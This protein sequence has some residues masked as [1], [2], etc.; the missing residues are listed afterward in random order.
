[1]LRREKRYLFLL[2]SV[3][4][5]TV[6]CGVLYS[7]RSEA[8]NNTIPLS[9][10]TGTWAVRDGSG[11]GTIDGNPFN[12]IIRKGSIKI[13]DIR[14]DPDGLGGY[15]DE[16]SKLIWEI[17]DSNWEKILES[18][19][20]SSP[21]SIHYE[22]TGDNQYSATYR[23]ETVAVTL[24]SENSGK[25]TD[26]VPAGTYIDGY[27]VSANLT[28]Y[29]D[30]VSDSD[31]GGCGNTGVGFAGILALLAISALRKN[32]RLGDDLTYEQESLH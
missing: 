32:A 6:F 4:L 12:V 14:L 22:N 16:S 29:V 5:V 30:K 15:V 2:A 7:E 13:T 11:S 19:F 27:Q 25:V 18:P 3:L 21:H 31:G 1:M 17:Y 23:G 26:S 24:L 10:L 20:S 28:Y 8:Y 9:A